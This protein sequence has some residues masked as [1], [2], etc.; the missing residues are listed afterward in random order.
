VNGLKNNGLND[1]EIKAYMDKYVI[2]YSGISHISQNLAKILKA[3]PS[4][5]QNM[6]IVIEDGSAWLRLEAYRNVNGFNDGFDRWEMDWVPESSWLG[7]Y[8]DE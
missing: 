3:Q 6:R 7:R 4:E 8:Q 5:Y 2:T 1:E